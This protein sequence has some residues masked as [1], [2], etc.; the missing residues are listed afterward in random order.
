MDTTI[1][2]SIELVQERLLQ[3]SRI[4]KNYMRFDTRELDIN[5][6]DL[7]NQ[8]YLDSELLGSYL[9]ELQNGRQ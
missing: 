7:A 3:N 5:A 2:E 1:L 9:K 6:L 8:I 4:L